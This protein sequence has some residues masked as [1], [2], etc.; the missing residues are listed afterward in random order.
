LE[1]TGYCRAEWRLRR[2]DG[3]S[4]LTEVTAARHESEAAGLSSMQAALAELQR[5]IPPP[6]EHFGGPG[7]RRGQLRSE[8]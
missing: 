7:A 1:A 5:L 6:P 8:P 3:N 4:V 2:K